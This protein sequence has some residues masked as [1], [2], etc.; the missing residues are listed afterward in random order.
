MDNITIEQVNELYE[1]LQGVNPEQ[2]CMGKYNHPK[3]SDKKAFN[4]IWFL[5]EHLRIIPSKFERCTT[6]GS[7]YNSE[8]EGHY[9]DEKYPGKFYCGGCDH[10]APNDSFEEQKF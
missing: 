9:N 2:V 1:F 5:Q 4:V 3:M 6:C 10:L 7:L 8:A